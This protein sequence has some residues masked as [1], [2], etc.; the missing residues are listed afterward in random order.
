M[1]DINLNAETPTQDVVNAANASVT[2]TDARG[3]VIGLRKLSPLDRMRLF[4]VVGSEGVK[5]EFYFGYAT[6][7]Y[8]VTSIDGEA[9]VRP[10]N[11]MQLEALVQRLDDD[12]LAAIAK[13]VSDNFSPS[14]KT[15]DDAKDELKNA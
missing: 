15:A 10:T 9:V 11:E 6:L 2:V 8:H 14:Q 4:R 7:A 12:G 3:R 5:N 1:V 13:G